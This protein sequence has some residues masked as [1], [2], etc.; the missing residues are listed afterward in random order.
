M[1]SSLPARTAEPGRPRL[2]NG[3]TVHGPAGI[4]RLRHRAEMP[5]LWASAAVSAA[6]V[7]AWLA[8]VTWLVAVPAP[9]G[10]AKEVRDLF[11][12]GNAV[13]GAQVLLAVPL[14]PLGVWGA[15]ALLYARMRASSVQ[16]SPTQFPE[17]YRMVV[18]AAERFG[19][20]RVPDAYVVLGNG[21]INAFAAG[22][23]FRR[24]VAVYSD[25]F[26]VGG[27]AR[28]PEALRFV[29]SH[30]VGHL[31]AG[32]ISFWRVLVFQIVSSVP[33]LG[34]ALS[35]AQEYT[36]DNHGYDIAPAG[37]PGLTGLL[38]AG[39][40]LGAQVNLHATADRAA[41]ERGL[42]VHAVQWTS[43]HPVLTWRAHALRDRSRPGRLM[44]RPKT[45]WYPP[46]SPVGRDRSRDWPTPAEVL[47]RLDEAGPRVP[48]AEEQL[49]RYPGLHYAVDRDE[50]RL[51]DP[52]P[53]GP[54]R[55]GPAGADGP[56]G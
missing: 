36:A 51:A 28:D 35:R 31:A 18:E 37:A 56:V 50:L 8:L 7:A 23:G 46:V 55:P 33:L 27:S 53:S 30:E 38:G 20:R 44:V 43:T 12:G 16:M 54:P 40:Y 13:T 21:R 6:A 9:S 26:E 14:L 1:T 34:K 22:H 48:G 3:A 29:I 49:G 19:L 17:G 25:L 4:R 32:H 47:A 2:L 10:P 52:T 42:W 24:F 45:A 5:L 41:H 11:V 15:R 39:K